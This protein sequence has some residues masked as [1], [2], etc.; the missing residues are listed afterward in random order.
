[1]SERL[2]QLEIKISY[3]EQANV[4]LSDTVNKQRLELRA[5]RDQLMVLAGRMEAAQ[6]QA[7]TYSAEEEKPPHY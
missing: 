6:A 3:L 2:E 4:E 5:L 7:T 1:M